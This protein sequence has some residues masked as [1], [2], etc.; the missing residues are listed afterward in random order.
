[1]DGRVVQDGALP[2]LDI[3]PGGSQVITLPV[4][5]PDLQPGQESFLNIYFALATD[6][7][8]AEAGHEI[9]WEQMALPYDVPAPVPI[10]LDHLSVLELV[11]DDAPCM[12]APYMAGTATIRGPE[13]CIEFDKANGRLVHWEFNGSALLSAGPS[14]N[15]W[16]APTDN[17]GI[18]L[19]TEPPPQTLPI[20]LQAGLDQLSYNCEVV[21]IDQPA[22]QVVRLHVQAISGSEAHPR[23]LVHEHI[24]TIYGDGEILLE[25]RI[26]TDANLPVLPRVGLT[27]ILPP[28]FEQ[29]TWFG[30]GP[31]ENYRDRQEGAAIG[32]YSGTVDEQYVP[33][34]MPQENGNKTDVRWLAL[35]NE[36]GLG[37]LAVGLAPLEFRV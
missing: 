36:A 20:W 31:H 29:L 15:I 33:Y 18:K 28:G 4:Q 2:R 17:D 10:P 12:A 35:T 25:N 3:P 21:T 19:A 6:T 8:W 30:R 14:L 27:M 1:V 32:R 22:P 24:Y 16:R 9:A 23:A 5:K 37:L 7:S 13:F 34:I 26:Q 11:Q